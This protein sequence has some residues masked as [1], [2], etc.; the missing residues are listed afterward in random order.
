M[1]SIPWKRWEVWMGLCSGDPTGA[2]W[3]L[4]ERGLA[5]LC[6]G[7]R[8][9]G[10][11]RSKSRRM[12]PVWM[13]FQRAGAGM[14]AWP[15][16]PSGW[17]ALVAVVW[18]ESLGADGMVVTATRDVPKGSAL[19]EPRE[20]LLWDGI[21]AA[22]KQLGLLQVLCV[23]P[24]VP[25]HGDGLGAPVGSRLGATALCGV[26]RRKNVPWGSS[27]IPLCRGNSLSIPIPKGC[28]HLRMPQLRKDPSSSTGMGNRTSSSGTQRPPAPTSCPSFTGRVGQV[29]NS[30]SSMSEPFPLG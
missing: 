16:F 5:K 9:G 10:R 23:L 21:P 4:G 6:P 14:G 1:R 15:G 22:W 12:A 20:W 8:R 29:W 13:V 26:S 30:G 3:L 27:S 28:V 7:G 2:A 18:V 19:P 24:S 17:E 11:P 25:G